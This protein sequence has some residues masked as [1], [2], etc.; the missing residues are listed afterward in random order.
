MK[1]FAAI[2]L[3][4]VLAASALTGCRRSRAKETTI[5]TTM[6]ITV[7][8]TVP[9]TMPATMPTIDHPATENPTDSTHDATMDTSATGENGTE[10]PQ[11]RIR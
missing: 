8:T 9:T 3:S 11:S 2:A 6:P 10:G 4:V 1:K 5:P 7:P